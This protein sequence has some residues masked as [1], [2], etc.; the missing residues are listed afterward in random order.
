MIASAPRVL[1][2]D[3]ERFFREAIAEALASQGIGCATADDGEAALAAVVESDFGVVVLDVG[4]SDPSGIE[5]LRRLTQLDPSLR[6]IV[7]APQLEHDL[8]LEAL[9]LE[10]CDYLAKPLH[11]EELV[12]SVRRALASHDVE[13]RWT[14]LRDRTCALDS[15]IAD[16]A[17][18]AREC[19]PAERLAV[20]GGPIAESVSVV[21][22][23]GKASLMVLSEAGD[24]LRV[25]AATGN[26]VAVSEMQPVVPGEGVAGI[27]ISEDAPLVVADVDRDERFAERPVRDQYRSTSLVVTPINAAGRPFGVLC[28]T[29]RE[30]GGSFGSEDVALLRVLAREVAHLLGP[31]PPPDARAAGVGEAVAVAPADGALL[32]DPGA[33]AGDDSELARA[34]CEVI[35]GAIE[36]ERLVAESLRAVAEAL[37]ASPVALHLIENKSGSLLLEGQAEDAD[38]VDRD[39]LDRGI[40]LTGVVVQTGHLVATDHPDKDPRFAPEAD[41]PADGAVRPLICVPLKIRGKTLGVLRAFPTGSSPA[42]ARTAETLAAAMSAALRNVLLYRSLLDSID[43]VARARRERGGRV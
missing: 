35:A 4:L 12:L 38:G 43:E 36:P 31:S 15:R 34:I 28:A 21:L 27:A 40:G 19:E 2:V 39:C 24:E 26:E 18:L 9:R 17:E 3:D 5:V 33:V 22:G 1:V 10:A 29:D 16:L 6:V 14:A 7:V 25:A 42:S 37:P 13:M 20:L 11:E 41:T 8:V 32:R 23:A 30:D